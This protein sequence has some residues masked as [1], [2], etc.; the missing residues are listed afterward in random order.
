MYKYTLYILPVAILP[1]GLRLVFRTLCSELLCSADGAGFRFFVANI[2][3]RASL[4]ITY[5]CTTRCIPLPRI[6]PEAIWL[7]PKF[8]VHYMQGEHQKYNQGI[9]EE[10]RG[11]TIHYGNWE[12]WGAD[13]HGLWRVC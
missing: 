8:T 1:Q 10:S 11:Y 6:C 7:D 4:A 5:D 9:G 3:G 12:T 2:S 13:L